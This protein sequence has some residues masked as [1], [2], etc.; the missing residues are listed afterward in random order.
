MTNPS[1]NA[2]LDLS[3]VD[4]SVHI[5]VVLDAEFAEQSPA[6]QGDS[7]IMDLSIPPG[8]IVTILQEHDDPNLPTSF[9]TT[10][11]TELLATKY[12]LDCMLYVELPESSDDV[13]LTV[14]IFDQPADRPTEG[15]QIASGSLTPDDD[16]SFVEVYFT[17]TLSPVTPSLDTHSVG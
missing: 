13:M 9:D 14:S 1:S 3:T 8:T 15:R 2:V 17:V 10:I 12:Q 16:D 4:G 11:S 6:Q 7:I 5:R